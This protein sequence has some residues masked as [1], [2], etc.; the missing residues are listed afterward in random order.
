MRASGGGSG[1]YGNKRIATTLDTSLTCTP[2]TTGGASVNSTAGGQNGNAG[3][4]TTIAGGNLGTLTAGGGGAGQGAPFP[5]GGGAGGT[6]SGAW[7]ETITGADG[8]TSNATL[9]ATGVYPGGSAPRGGP[10]GCSNVGSN[11]RAPG[12]AG[13]GSNHL[14]SSPSGAGANGRIKITI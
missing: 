4:N 1:A 10:G 5:T 7:D 6:A 13:A 11:G 8:F 12:G 2:G 3:A 14:A 9:A